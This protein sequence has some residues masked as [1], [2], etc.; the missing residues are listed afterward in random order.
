MS[1]ATG[2]FVPAYVLK[3]IAGSAA[4]PEKARQAALRTLSVDQDF[5]GQRVQA[6]RAAQAPRIP[7]EPGVSAAQVP[8]VRSGFVPPYVLEHVAQSEE[9]GD[10][11][12]ESARATLKMDAKIRK[13][14]AALTGPAA[15]DEPHDASAPPLQLKR[16]IYD[17]KGSDNLPGTLARAEGAGRITDRQ[18]NNV[19]DGIGI[20]LKFFHT[21]LGRNSLDD[22]GG[23]VVATVHFDETPRDRYGYNNAF[24]NGTQFAFGDGDGIIFDY[25]TDSLDVVAHEMIHAI[26]QHTAGLDYVK[27]VGGLNE[28]ISDVFAA[29]VEQWHFNQTAADA[30]WLTGQSLF[31]VAIKGP[32]LRDIAN[33]GTA[34]NDPILGRDSQISHFSQYNDGLD[35]HVTSGIPNRAFYLAAMGFGGFAWEKAGKIWYATLTDSRIKAVALTATFKQWADVTVDQANTLFGTSAAIIVRNAWVAVGVLV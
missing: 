32:A 14:R 24:W 31:P 27:Q 9:A 10:E 17:A 20:T 18:I 25:F 2:H 19:Y 7:D 5:R 35:V 3:H 22:N 33:P 11:A 34:F 16:L 8:I 29:L 23:N 15:R 4:A 21:V 28:S 30:D 1:R 6:L 13:Q 12:R 26:T